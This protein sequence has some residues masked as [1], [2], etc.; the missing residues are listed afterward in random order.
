LPRKKLARKHLA[1]KKLAAKKIGANKFGAKKMAAKVKKFGVHVESR[2]P[3]LSKILVRFL[4]SHIGLF[5][6][7]MAYA[8]LGTRF[9]F[10]SSPTYFL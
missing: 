8:V 9:F 7:S 2:G 1:R 10:S 4:F 5:S 3:S 6:L